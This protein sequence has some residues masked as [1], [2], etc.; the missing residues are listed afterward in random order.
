MIKVLL[1]FISCVAVYAQEFYAKVE[2]INKYQVKS[3]VNGSVLSSFDIYEGKYVQ[4]EIIIKIDDELDKTNLDT[5]TKKLDILKNNLQ[6]AQ[7]QLDNIKQIAD[8]KKSQY[9]KFVTL[10]TRSQITKEADLFDYL[11]AQN[12][13]L[14]TREKVLSIKTQINDLEYAIANLKDTIKNKS[15]SAKNLYV[16]KVYVKKYDYVVPNTP[17]LEL[18]DISKAKIEIFVPLELAQTIQSKKIYIDDTPTDY[19]IDKIYKIADSEK[20]SSY[21]VE[22]LIDKQEYFSKLVKIEIK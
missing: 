11:N 16:Y 20:I 13:Y 10:T 6:L 12:Q 19:K 22:I 2:P 21:K 3:K 17:L 18:H 7:E 1:F 5:Y 4:D 14:S 8:T 15:I 9:E